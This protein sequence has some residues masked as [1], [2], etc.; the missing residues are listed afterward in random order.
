MARSKSSAGWLKEHFDAYLKALTS[1]FKTVM[2]RK[3]DALWAR[4]GEVYILVKGF[5]G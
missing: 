3:L 2:T 1:Q 5:K 4:L